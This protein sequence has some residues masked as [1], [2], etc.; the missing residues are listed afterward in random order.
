MWRTV[1]AVIGGFV[2]WC[3]IATVLDIGLR[4]ALP[5]YSQAEPILAFTLPM[6]LARLTIGVFAALAAGAAARAIAPASRIAPWIAGL[7]LLALFLPVHIHIGAR[8]PLWYHLSFLAP[9]APL[10]ALGASM[11]P[12]L[13][14]GRDEARSVA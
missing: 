6:E 13:R 8:L 12:P 7:L 11:C 3:V 4:L 14:R 2:A 1:L 5:G 10:V 9:L